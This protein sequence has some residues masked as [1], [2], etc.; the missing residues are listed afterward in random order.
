MKPSQHGLHR[1]GRGARENLFCCLAGRGYYTDLLNGPHQL[2]RVV[3]SKHLSLTIRLSFASII[4]LVI[5]PVCV[6]AQRPTAPASELRDPNAEAR[7]RQQREAQLRSAELLQPASKSTAPTIPL[8]QMAE[9]FKQIQILRNNV[10]RHL[11]SEKP[12]DY[13][14]IANETEEI[15]KRAGRLAEHLDRDTTPTEKKEESAQTEVADDK[16]KD[17]LIR[18]CKHIDSF[19]ENPSFKTPDVYDVKQAERAR[20][21]LQDVVKLSDGILKTAERLKKTQKN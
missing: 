10:V 17:A 2:E 3:M 7:E 15:N 19:T 1:K 4:C 16:V 20:H 13:K 14:F 9:D 5:L 21:D 11:L 12:L 18:M 8:K 6:Y